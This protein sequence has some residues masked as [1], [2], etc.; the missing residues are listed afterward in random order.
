M[1]NGPHGPDAPVEFPSGAATLRDEGHLHAAL[2]DKVRRQGVVVLPLGRGT[3]RGSPDSAIL[4]DVQGQVALLHEV[5]AV[6]Q[7]GQGGDVS[8]RLA[9]P[10]GVGTPGRET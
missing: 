6:H 8:R 4:D 3:R 10:R 9:T 7:Q 5:H 2:L 1:M